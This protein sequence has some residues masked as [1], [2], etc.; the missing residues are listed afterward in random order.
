M[1]ALL[2][3]GRTVRVAA[4][5]TRLGVSFAYAYVAGSNRGPQLLRRYFERAGAGFVKLGQVLA[6]RYDLLPAAYC[7]E[8]ASL[9]DRLPASDSRAIVA[10]IEQDLKRP[11]ANVYRE[12]DL[13]PLSS[14]S[15]A[16]VHA[17][18]LETGERVV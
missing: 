16:Q 4:L 1:Q 7:D 10:T 2:Y 9:L 5:T 8:L 18:T 3:L 14:A 6:T 15:V 12:F 11:L 13:T 17:A